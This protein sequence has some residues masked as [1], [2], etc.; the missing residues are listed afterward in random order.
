M[1]DILIDTSIII[2]YLRQKDK[3]KTIN[4]K[5]E[6]GQSKLFISIITHAESYSGKSIWEKKEAKENLKE[7]L[8][9]FQILSLDEKTSEKAGEIRVSYS[10]SITDAIIA[11]TAITH[12]LQLRR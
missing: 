12:K 2:D 8:S 11:A 7:L 5:L 6:S 9:G 10:T 3:S 1:A 4:F